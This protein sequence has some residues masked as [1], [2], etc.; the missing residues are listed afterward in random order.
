MIVKPERFPLLMPCSL[1]EW[2]DYIVEQA[3]RERHAPKPA[4][5]QE[6]SK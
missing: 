2:M 4:T 1:A 6:L 5:S 3:D